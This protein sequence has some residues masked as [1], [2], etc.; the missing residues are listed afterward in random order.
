MSNADDARFLQGYFKTGPGQYDE[1]DLF[2]GIRLP[3]LR[4][5]SILYR[6]I[7]L[8]KTEML[9]RS[10][11]HEDRLLA[12]L[13]LVLSFR[14]ADEA[15]RSD[16]YRV[17]LGNTKFI[18]NWD[19][20]DASAGH[21]VGAYLWG[22]DDSPLYIL[23]NSRNLWE[24]R[25]AVIATSHSIKNGFFDSTLRISALLLND[26]E[27]LIHKAV[28]WM[29]REVGK[30]DMEAEE[31]FL[32]GCYQAYAAHNAPLRHRKIPGE[33]AS[34]LPERGYLNFRLAFI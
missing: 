28:G 13:I 20:V 3:E 18:N 29:L 17:Y 4:R 9:L 27:D 26:K 24:R 19:L 16:I 14:E 31:N 21:I 1:G 5:L 12:L 7:P 8:E 33:E 11:Y 25:I 22:K 34:G 6:A 15:G 2:R 30:R 32:A 23:A 10:R